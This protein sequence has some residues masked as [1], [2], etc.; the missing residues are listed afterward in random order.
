MRNLNLTMVAA[1]LSATAWAQDAN[2]DSATP[3]DL[4]S[5]QPA[6]TLLKGLYNHS[7]GFIKQ[8]STIYASVDDGS[9]KD[10]VMGDDGSVYIK[11]PVQ[12][13]MTN[14]WLKATK[15]TGDT[16]VVTLPQT[17]YSS[18]Y[19]GETTYNSLY[20]MVKGQDV[21]G[22]VNYVKDNNSNTIRLIMRNDSIVKAPE[23]KDA[24]LG[25]TYPSGNWTGFGSSVIV[26]HKVADATTAPADA[27]S[28]QTYNM[29][30]NVDDNTT[31]TRVVNV[32]IE[33]NDIFLGN[34]TDNLTKQWVK[35]RIEGDKAI[36][37]RKLYVGLD[38]VNNAHAYFFPA[39]KVTK[40]IET[41]FGTSTY[42][43]I[44]FEKQLVFD[45][46]AA[47]KTLKSNGGFV[48]NQGS[49]TVNASDAFWKP[50]LA[51]WK[52]VV[53][54]PVAP[55]I[56]Y[57]EPYDDMMNYS[58]IQFFVDKTDAEGNQ[59]NSKNLYYNIYIDDEL[60]TFNPGEYM[61]MEPMTDIPYDYVNNW[62]FYI[63]G[64][65]HTVYFY[66]TG[67][68]KIGIQGYYLDGDKK[69]T[70]E[71]ATYIIDAAGIHAA[72]GDNK[73][74]EHVDYLDLSG[75]AVAKPTHGLYIKNITYTDGTVKTVKT[76]VR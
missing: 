27:Q 58:Y 64:Q 35:G 54:A 71:M 33:G 18:T 19:E 41:F 56:D 63:D 20:R 28:A 62:D 24:I 51:P 47:N 49:E 46:D 21:D 5:Q 39:D 42:D 7:E 37:D 12:G 45:Y 60:M 29:T 15:G 1:L 48:I 26:L 52:E 44:W 74:V 9:A 75:R 59:L 2:S 57:F 70:S 31:D 40:E 11:N 73:T 10:V 14:T 8:L 36:F 13:F 61:V 17:I 16:L 66:Y 76:M 43:S 32:A 25:M 23:D 6:G 22:Q 72:T 67:F 55:R 3:T 30:Y 50:A 68:N 38:T 65:K 34:L 53:S 69:L 4:I